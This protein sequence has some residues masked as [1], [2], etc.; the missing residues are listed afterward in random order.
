MSVHDVRLP[1]T[2]EADPVASGL[3]EALAAHARP[4]WSG[5]VHHAASL[6]PGEG[7]MAA[8]RG[9]NQAGFVVRGLEAAE[10]RLAAEDRGLQLARPEEE[11]RTSVRVSRL[12]VLT[13]DG[14]ERFYRNVEALLR[15]HGPRLLAIRLE[16][17][18]HDL[19][20]LLYGPE[21]VARL[22][23]VEHKNE[24]AALLLA[25]ARQWSDGG[26]GA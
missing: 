7:V 8:L 14:S 2:V 16:I 24:V 15:R 19:G 1:K 20:E 4:L 13:H 18:E 10:R 6:V 23:L 3:L 5:G 22:V 21:R 12:L 9:A 11:R 17:D 25:L 26:S